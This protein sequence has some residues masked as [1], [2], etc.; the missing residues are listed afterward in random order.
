[1]MFRELEPVDMHT[2]ARFRR[3]KRSAWDARLEGSTPLD[4]Y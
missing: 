3:T 4:Y 1:M 2:A